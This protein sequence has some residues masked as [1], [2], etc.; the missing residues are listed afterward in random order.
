MNND[1]Q[2]FKIPEADYINPGL[3]EYADNPL[4]SALPPI[5]NTASVVK[6]LSKR[7]V[8]QESEKN[9]PGHIRVHAI[10]RLTKDFF[11]PLSSHIV[12]ERKLS[13]LIR[14]GYLGRN[15]KHASFKK[16]LNNGYQRIVEKDLD[17]YM[18][19]DVDSTASSMAVIGISGSG[20]T[21]TFNRLLKAYPKAIYHPEYNMIQIPWLKVDCP[22]DGTLTEF[23][24]SFFMALDRRLGTNYLKKYGGSRKG[25]GYLITSAAQLSLIHAVGLLVIDE[26]QHLDLAKGGGEK[27]MINFLVKLVNTIGV[28]VVL[29]GTPKALPIFAGEFRKARRSAGEGSVFWDRMVKDESWDDFI[30]ELWQFQWLKEPKP[31]TTIIRDTLYDLSQGI[32]DIVVKLMCLAQARAILVG[33]EFITVDLLKQVYNDEFTTVHSMLNALRQGNKKKISEYG[34]L[35]MPEIEGKLL[36]TF[37]HLTAIKPEQHSRIDTGVPEET[38]K[39]KSAIAMLI[40]MGVNEDIA[41]PLVTDALR[42]TPDISVIQLIHSTTAELATKKAAQ[43]NIP[44]Q[45]AK[46]KKTKDWGQ[47]PEEDLRNVFELKTGTMYESIESRGLIYPVEDMLSG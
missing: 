12:L 44:K 39:A 42:R 10:A 11:E 20:K 17:A 40:E 18:H 45:K 6:L 22:H 3:A 15:P 32:L 47:L 8:F 30:S 34:D 41:V 37:D 28:S 7:P 9:L 26:F 1:H 13:I 23:C 4:I 27:K 35:F 38:D 14:Q 25:I 21:T 43:A 46:N 5:M 16:H 2:D 19:D 31:L 29:I 24:L 36:N 33:N